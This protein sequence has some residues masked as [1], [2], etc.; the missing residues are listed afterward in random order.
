MIGYLEHC[1]TITT[2]KSK[3]QPAKAGKTKKRR[4]G[5]PTIPLRRCCFSVTRIVQSVDAGSAKPLVDLLSSFVGNAQPP[6]QLDQIIGF[7]AGIQVDRN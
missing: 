2:R 4:S 7:G 5:I 3:D 1:L 6:G